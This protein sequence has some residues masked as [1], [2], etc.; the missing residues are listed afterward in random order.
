MQLALA[1]LIG[2]P[3]IAIIIDRFSETVDL[4]TVLIGSAP[5]WSQLL[6]G[7]IVGV[8]SAVLA[9]AM[10]SLPFMQK[11]NVKYTSMFG[12]FRL[13]W[14]EI[15]FLS[16]CAGVGEELLFRGAIQPLLAIIPTSILFVAI[17]GYLHPKNWRL[18]IYGLFMTGVICIIGLMAI[19]FGL[20]SSM[21][22]HTLIDVYLLSKMQQM[23][24]T[25]PEESSEALESSERDSI[26]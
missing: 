9:Q 24:A 7:I 6:A 21:I 12:N 11:M 25:F 3:I 1:T 10:V 8:I 17:H 23:A 5:L 19:R 22:A 2:M 13:T 16:L 18:S 26:E 4:A 15:L 14:S 20:I